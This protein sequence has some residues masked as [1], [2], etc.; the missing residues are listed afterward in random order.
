[1]M[2]ED[3]AIL[4]CTGFKKCNLQDCI[5]R[6]AHS[7]VRECAARCPQTVHNE[8]AVETDPEAIAEATGDAVMAEL[9]YA[10][11]GGRKKHVPI[12]YKRL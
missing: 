9:V 11:E 2:T 5:H 12:T 8:C 10:R 1:M 3:E 7:R 4:R 6:K